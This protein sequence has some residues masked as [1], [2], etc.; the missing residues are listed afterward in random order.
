M[1]AELTGVMGQDAEGDELAPERKEKKDGVDA[2]FRRVTA[3]LLNKHHGDIA[4]HQD[5]ELLQRLP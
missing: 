2:S 3:L 4:L 1:A 5:A